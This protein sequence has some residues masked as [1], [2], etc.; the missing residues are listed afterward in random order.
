MSSYFH[1]Q[2][3]SNQFLYHLEK[4]KAID[5]SLSKAIAD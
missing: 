4:K 3:S 1:L 5:I 2:I